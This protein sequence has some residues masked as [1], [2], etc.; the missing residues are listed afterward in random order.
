MLKGR[1]S[2]FYY[3]KIVGRMY[4]FQ[5]MVAMTKTH[6]KTEENYQK[7]LFE[8]RETTFIRTILENLDKTRLKCL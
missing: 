4:D 6:F 3:D 1:A 2:F 7:Y 8:W 5:T